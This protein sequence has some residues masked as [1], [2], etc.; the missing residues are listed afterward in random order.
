ML[1]VVF[2]KA[3]YI[4]HGSVELADS[5][6]ILNYLTETYA[7][8][9]KVNPSPDPEMNGIAVAVRSLCEDHLY[10]GLV[11]FRWAYPEVW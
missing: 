5:A 3:P 10:W 7:D 8:K 4:K 6:F 1:V 2:F 9:I 11:W